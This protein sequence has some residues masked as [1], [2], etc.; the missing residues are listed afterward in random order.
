MIDIAALSLWGLGVFVATIFLTRTIR[1]HAHDRGLVDTPNKRSSHLVPTPRGGGLAFVITIS[2][3]IMLGWAAQ[4]WDVAM[5]AA[6][7]V[8][9]LPVATI[10]WIDD[11][12][13]VP[14]WLRFL[15]H[16]FA[17]AI[18]TTIIGPLAGVELPYWLCWLASVL[19]LVW[20]INL[21][22]FMDGIDGLA[23]G[24]A[25]FVTLGWALCMVASGELE[26]AVWVALLICV[27]VGGFLT[28]NWPPAKIF[29]GDVG[30]GFLGLLLGA[31]VLLSYQISWRAACA[32]VILLA[33]FAADATVTL[34]RR[35]F[36]GEAVWT[37]HRSHAYQ[38]QARKHGSHRTVTVSV[39]IINALF[40]LPVAM[41]VSIGWLDPLL[42]I[43]ATYIPVT[44][45]ALIAGAGTPERAP[46]T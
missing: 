32:V 30:S 17:A 12:G 5:T 43:A 8:S 10:G 20:L 24:E 26:P 22:N 27:A 36:R 21:A 18:A 23:G 42:G 1:T 28:L 4:W 37:A 7:L 40:L 25:C 13:H 39:M 45:L 9:G 16:I 35:A 29:M 31:L 11:H 2:A 33:V 19:G 14:A 6:L 38:H 46:G 34:L 15:I 41:A 44:A 3:G